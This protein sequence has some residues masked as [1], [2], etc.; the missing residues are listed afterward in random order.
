MVMRRRWA[1]SE[2]VGKFTFA[3]KPA[4]TGKNRSKNTGPHAGCFAN[5]RL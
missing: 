3:I 1:V 2:G 5:L 4:P